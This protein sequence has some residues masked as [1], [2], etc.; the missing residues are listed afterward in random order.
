MNKTYFRIFISLCFVMSNSIPLL[1]QYNSKTNS[2]DD[3]LS[4]ISAPQTF[5]Q[6][7]SKL[8]SSITCNPNS[9]YGITAGGDVEELSL[10]GNS[11]TVTGTLISGGGFSIAYCNNLNSSTLSPTFYTDEPNIRYY[12]GSSWSNT[13]I[14]PAANLGG[15]GNFLYF[16]NTIPP[17]PF[18]RT[19]KKYNGT[20]T[21][22]IFTRTNRIIDVGDLAV[23]D[24]GNVYFTTTADSTT[25]IS[26]S[27]VVVSSS[28]QIVKQ[29]PF[30]Y[31]CYNAY[32][33]FILNN[34]FYIGLGSS[35]PTSPNTL[36]P[37]IFGNN[38]AIAG[39]PISMPNSNYYDLASCKAGLPL[40]IRSSLPQQN[41]INLYP[42]PITDESTLRFPDNAGVKTIRILNILGQ[43]IS[44]FETRDK[45]FVIKK[46]SLVSGIYFIEISISDD[47]IIET[48]K[49]IID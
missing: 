3:T 9:F 39:T 21:S 10:V 37:V 16:V 46:S 48:I 44:Q 13:N 18:S 35:N 4:N 6:Q 32:G 24:N 11:I 38:T 47:S 1:A 26:D 22:T 12:N 40:N 20:N 49:L 36:L 15:N 29:L 8:S 42:N 34:V 23:D 28:G 45:S 33:S 19:I 2:F 43:P 5:N 41:T 30:T 7:Y 31:N 14:S 17:S 25:F 27:I